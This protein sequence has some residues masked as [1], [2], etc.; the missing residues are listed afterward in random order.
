[1]AIAAMAELATLS[2]I[3]AWAQALRPYRNQIL[4]NGL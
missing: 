3:A 2:A 1:V 4:Q